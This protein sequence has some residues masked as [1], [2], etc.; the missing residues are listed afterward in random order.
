MAA[1][2]D[3][4]DHANFQYLNQHARTIAESA[5]GVKRAILSLSAIL[6]LRRGNFEPFGPI[7]FKA[8]AEC[9]MYAKDGR[10]DV[11]VQNRPSVLRDL[12]IL[13]VN[14]QTLTKLD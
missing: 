10:E 14:K 1:Y 11:R 3:Q 7:P 5:H 9:R 2:D 4:T 8:K 12:C 13:T 6:S